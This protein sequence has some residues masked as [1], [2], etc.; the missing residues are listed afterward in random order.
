M[1][2]ILRFWFEKVEQSVCRRFERP[3]REGAKQRVPPEGRTLCAKEI[4]KPNS[5]PDRNRAATISLGRS[6]P[7]GSC[8]LPARLAASHRC[9]PSPE[10]EAARMLGLA[11]AGGCLAGHVTV[12]PVSSYLTFSP[13]PCAEGVGSL[14]LWPCSAR[15]RARMLSGSV[16]CGVR[17]FLR[18]IEVR[19]R[20]PR[21][22]WQSDHSTTPLPGQWRS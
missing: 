11:P 13:S 20:S 15:R 3:V 7:I 22:L 4:D 19:P 10:R 14:F 1:A 18:R 6:S 16:L 9:A 5:V 2:K 21:T 17:T 8:G 12:P